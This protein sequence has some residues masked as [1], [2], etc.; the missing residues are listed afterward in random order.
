MCQEDEHRQ[1]I[2]LPR[3]AYIITTTPIYGHGSVLQSGRLARLWDS[4]VASRGK[5]RRAKEMRV[6][7]V[8]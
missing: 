3:I 1:L 2:R 8:K 7:L 4:G 5:R 6:E